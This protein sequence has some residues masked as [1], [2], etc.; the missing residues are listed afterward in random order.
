MRANALASAVS[1]ARS[2]PRRAERRRGRG[3][4]RQQNESVRR[5]VVSAA[6]AP[7]LASVLVADPSGLTR[8]IDEA[9]DAVVLDCDGVIWHG[10]SL[11]PGAKAAI[12]ALRA[13]GKRVFFVTNNSTKSREHYAAKFA[14]LGI[15]ASKY[16]IYTSAYATACYL[17]REGFDALI[18]EKG[19]DGEHVDD[20]KQKTVYVIGEKG[21]LDELEE[22]GIDVEGGVYDSVRCTTTDWAEMSEWMDEEDDVGAVVVGSDSSFTFAKLAYASLQIQRGAKFV[23][24][25]PDA[26]DMLGP[27]LYPGAGAIVNAVATACGSQPEIY[28][29]KPSSFMLDL[30]SEHTGIDLSRTLVI[31]DRLDTDVAFGKAG[32][33]A[34]V[35]LVLTGVTGLEEMEAAV[36]KAQ[37][38]PAVA[39]MI[40]DR[41]VGS[42]AELCGLDYDQNELV[43]TVGDR[44]ADISGDHMLDAFPLPEDESPEDFPYSAG[45]GASEDEEEEFD[46][47]AFA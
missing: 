20:Y 12:E 41:V 17:K 44:Q 23:A 18:G 9:I 7:S 33:A 37:T 38:D 6:A 35:A 25:N 46:I 13:K 11:I 4:R 2:T 1:I 28:C 36:E 31:G 15:D 32:N 24:T 5:R 19:D 27:G 10:D 39:A 45:P 26:G 16:E 14:A 34:I 22:A 40:P 42:L 29:G 30:L 3:E 47:N 43:A 8:E 21:I